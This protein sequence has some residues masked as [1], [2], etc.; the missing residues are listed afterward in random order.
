MRFTIVT[1]FPGA[2]ESIL[3]AGVL[4]KAI[5]KGL[6]VVDFV[7]PRDFTHDR[8][9]TVDDTPYGG[10]PGMVMKVE[11]V[12]MALDSID[13]TPHRM[14][15][16]PTGAPLCH[17]RVRE[18]AELEHIAL[19]CGRYEGID[20]R[21]TELCI[22]ETISLG[23]FVM[24][25]GEIAAMAI[26]DAVS[27]FV[28]GVLGEQTSTEEESFSDD[29]IEYPHYTRP[30]EFRGLEVPEILLGGNHEHIRKWRRGESIVRTAKARPDLFDRHVFTDEDRT[31]AS[32]LGVDLAA[33]SYVVLA[34]HPVLDRHRKVVTSSVT[35]L[36]VHDI[37]RSAMTYGLAGFLLVTPV[38][39]QRE[40]IE[41]VVAVWQNEM[42]KVDADTRSDALARVEAVA[43]VED[44][45][46]WVADKHGT[47]PRL[48]ATSA[49]PMERAIGFAELRSAA[50]ED[51]RPLILLFGTG[52]G[53]AQSA[54][55]LSEQV[56]MPVAG[57]PDF[58]HLSVRSAV[59]AA[60]D[61][62]F[63]A[64]ADAAPKSSST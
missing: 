32:E 51:S 20:E 19:V 49:R 25:G 64:R 50:L 43:S 16:A 52:W 59:A 26:V 7:D 28:P 18:L 62:L 22:D 60:L 27:R 46:A 40:K 29:L 44:A 21:V 36:D 9:R 23:D 8:H 58:N 47:A 63:G 1:L 39:A 11:P 2:F 14:M 41:R 13:G 38:A 35:T 37:A 34:H 61:R 4:G 33:R 45:A 10:G 30:R 3:A 12:A 31:L 17:E 55:A 6:V 48:I 42:D 15:M 57:R 5:E 56:L 24:T 53:L 54:I